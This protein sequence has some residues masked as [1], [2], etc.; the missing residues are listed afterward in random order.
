MTPGGIDL[1]MK[2]LMTSPPFRRFLLRL[3]R[4]GGLWLPG[5]ASGDA[6]MH[7]REGARS[8][9]L[10]MI[11]LAAAGLPPGATTETVLV[12]ILREATPEEMTSDRSDDA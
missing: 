1:D 9:A 5:G 2:L 10:E 8:L 6:Q 11:R 7:Q 3:A 12:T 4:L